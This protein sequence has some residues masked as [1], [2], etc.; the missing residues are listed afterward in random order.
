MKYAE[1]IKSLYDCSGFSS[2]TNFLENLFMAT[3]DRNYPDS[4]VNSEDSYLKT[5]FD[6]LTEPVRTDLH[7]RFHNGSFLEF[8]NKHLHD[9]VKIATFA[10]KYGA[11][12]DFDF[13]DDWQKRHL[14]DLIAEQFKEILSERDFDAKNLI[15]EGYK[16]GIDSSDLSANI[17]GFLSTDNNSEN[18]QKNKKIVPSKSEGTGEQDENTA[19]T[20]SSSGL[21]GESIDVDASVPSDNDESDHE[22][23]RTTLKKDFP[24]LRV[25]PKFSRKLR[26]QYLRQEYSVSPNAVVSVQTDNG[27]SNH[28]EKPISIY[29]DG[30]AYRGALGQIFN[31]SRIRSLLRSTP[32]LQCLSQEYKDIS[33]GALKTIMKNYVQQHIA[34]RLQDA[35]T[36][37]AKTEELNVKKLLST[38]KKQSLVLIGKAGSGKSTALR[39]LFLRSRGIT[40]YIR[41]S[42]LNGHTRPAILEEFKNTLI[43]NQLVF[44][45]GLDELTLSFDEHTFIQEL[46]DD[47]AERNIRFVISMRVDHYQGF[48]SLLDKYFSKTTLTQGNGLAVFEIQDFDEV[49]FIRAA[50]LVEKLEK[51]DPRHFKNK[52]PH[53]ISVREYKAIL[54]NMFKEQPLFKTALFSRYAYPLSEAMQKGLSMATAVEK[55]IKWECHDCIKSGNT[56]ER[57]PIFDAF[58][59]IAMDYLEKIALLVKGNESILTK[60]IESLRIDMVKNECMTEIVNSIKKSELTDPDLIKECKASW[61]NISWCLLHVSDDGDSVEFQHSIFKE[62]FLAKHLANVDLLDNEEDRN[63]FVRFSESPLFIEEYANQLRMNGKI[64]ALYDNIEPDQ[65]YAGRDKAWYCNWFVGRLFKLMNDGIK[66]KK[67]KLLKPVTQLIPKAKINCESKAGINPIWIEI[68]NLREEGLPVVP[69]HPLSNAKELAL[70]VCHNGT[71]DDYIEVFEAV[72]K[73]HQELFFESDADI[74]TS[75][76]TAL[77]YARKLYKKNPREHDGDYYI[78]M[79]DLSEYFREQHSEIAA[80]FCYWF[81][82]LLTKREEY[83]L[84]KRWAEKGLT[85]IMVAKVSISTDDYGGNIATTRHLSLNQDLQFDLCHTA[86]IAIVFKLNTDWV[87]YEK[88]YEIAVTIKSEQQFSVQRYEIYRLIKTKKFDEAFRILDE[89]GDKVSEEGYRFYYLYLLGVCKNRSKTLDAFDPIFTEMED[90]RDSETDRLKYVV[91]ALEICE[92]KMMFYHQTGNQ[93]ALEYLAKDNIGLYKEFNSRSGV[94]VCE[95][96]LENDEVNRSDYDSTINEVIWL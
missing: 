57:N 47:F 26:L 8:L 83:D 54:K 19:N 41:M 36:V 71:S 84:A 51:A 32:R 42:K 69:S 7:I 62:H 1:F 50:C 4:I 44:L 38:I 63:T 30:K 86:I 6:R 81:S 72:H 73:I 53:D 64:E 77:I 89:Y 76:Y 9:H 95:Y 66:V 96:I 39:W 27:D 37:N 52:F 65:Y 33:P 68:H 21:G 80:Y 74:E 16:T 46:T 22:A 17:P 82:G 60:E 48:T 88:Y 3:T 11:P 43:D 40:S 78:V 34:D 45:D 14:F 58:S 20:K 85:M 61:K 91:K 29:I 92:L 55:I 18:L 2:Q 87:E 13:T 94:S 90:I 24:N 67:G 35:Q 25:F 75:N 31:N 15:A 79:N 23:G 49:Q 56:K 59:K 28:I 5:F 12:S 70:D 10:E 93:I